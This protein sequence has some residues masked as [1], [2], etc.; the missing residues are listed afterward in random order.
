MTTATT[1]IVVRST[2]LDAYGHVNNARYVEYFEWG[3]FDWLDVTG[4]GAAVSGDGSAYV[5]VNVNVAYKKEARLGEKLTLKTAL[6]TMGKGSLVMA[7]RLENTSGAVVAEGE[8]VLA[9]FDPKARKGMPLPQ[10][11]VELLT[12]HVVAAGLGA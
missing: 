10:N 8:V 11:H 6:K 7:Q 1:S 9:A 2:E 3:R 12:P 5:V 4:L